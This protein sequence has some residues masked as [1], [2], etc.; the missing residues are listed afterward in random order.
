MCS[1][2]WGHRLVA[3]ENPARMVVFATCWVTISSLC[4]RA[5]HCQALSYSHKM[6]CSLSESLSSLDQ[7]LNDITLIVVNHIYSPSSGFLH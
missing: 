7:K 3:M 6:P 2:L 4:G 1:W 5:K